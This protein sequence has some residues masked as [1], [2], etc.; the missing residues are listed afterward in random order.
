MPI[1]KSNNEVNHKKSTV[2]VCSLQSS[3]QLRPQRVIVEEAESVLTEF[4][5]KW[6][7]HSSLLL[8]LDEF[9]DTHSGARDVTDHHHG[10]IWA[11]TNTGVQH[12]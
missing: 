3:A 7:S 8:C 1:I 11:I 6:S 4:K 9:D 12:H 10:N 2:S 5:W